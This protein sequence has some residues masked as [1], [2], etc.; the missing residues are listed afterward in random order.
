MEYD[1]A[2]STQAGLKFLQ[3]LTLPVTL[4]APINV[5]PPSREVLGNIGDLHTQ[6]YMRTVTKTS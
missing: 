3:R 5:M 2:A 6:Q 4:H 1:I